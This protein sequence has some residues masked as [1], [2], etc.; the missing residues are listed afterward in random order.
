MEASGCTTQTAE[1]APAHTS[2]RSPRALR[3]ALAHAGQAN[4]YV[5]LR[6]DDVDAMTSFFRDVIGLEAAGEGETVTFQ[7][8]KADSR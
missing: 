3:A 4:G 5:G 7:G 2:P 1:E 8:R 6:T